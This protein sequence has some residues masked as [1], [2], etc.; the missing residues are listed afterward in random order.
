MD[1]HVLECES[2]K[3]TLEDLEYC[4][5][6]WIDIE[7]YLDDIFDGFGTWFWKTSLDFFQALE[8]TSTHS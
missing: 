8:T 5:R 3:L 6:S 2:Y 1:H 7:R 4:V